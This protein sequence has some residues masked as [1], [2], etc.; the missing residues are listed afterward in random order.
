MSSEAILVPSSSSQ[1]QRQSS[2]GGQGRQPTYLSTSFSPIPLSASP[3]ND[4]IQEVPRDVQEM[5]ASLPLFARHGRTLNHSDFDDFLKDTSSLI[6][7]RHFSPGDNVIREGDQSRAI[8][9]IVKGTV[10]VTAEDGEINYAELGP[11]SHFG[12]IGVLFDI[13]RTA[14]VTAKTKCTLAVLTASELQSLL[15]N[16]PDVKEIFET[17][18]KERYDA[19]LAA[20]ARLWPSIATATAFT[21]TG[22][23]PSPRLEKDSSH[24]SFKELDA[25]RRRSR[26]PFD[27]NSLPPSPSEGHMSVTLADFLPPEDIAASS[28]STPVDSLSPVDSSPPIAP[29]ISE[30]TMP[31]TAVNNIASLYG[32]RRR[33]SV[34]VWSDDRLMQFA[35]SVS[36][37]SE[38]DL[39]DKHAV[40]QPSALRRPSYELFGNNRKCSRNVSDGYGILGKDCMARILRFLDFKQRMR[41]RR[42]SMDILKL[43]LDPIVNLTSSVDLS[44]WNKRVDDKVLQDVLCFCGAGLKQLNLR[45]CWSITDRGILTI[46][47]YAPHIRLLNL[48]SVWEITDAALV[49]LSQHCPNLTVVDL[50]NCRK[51]TSM[52]LLAMLDAC[53]VE[54]LRLSYCKSLSDNVMYHP[55]WR[56]VRRVNFQRCTGVGDKGF[57]GWGRKSEQGGGSTD[58]SNDTISILGEDLMT[59][60]TGSVS[61]LSAFPGKLTFALTCLSLSDCSFLTDATIISLPH[62]PELTTLSLSFCCALSPISIPP[63][64]ASCPNLTSLDVSFCGSMMT[65]AG[66]ALIARGLLALEMLSLR[67]CIQV[68]ER[69]LGELN[70]LV[71]LRILNIG[72]LKVDATK[73]NSLRWRIIQGQG[74]EEVENEPASKSGAAGLNHRGSR[75]RASTA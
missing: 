20:R 68:T 25:S 16:Y 8:F 41:I 57:Q 59:A 72:S 27:D 12:E 40:R 52:G 46:A 58:V 43:L 5:L 48:A 66:L 18:A 28:S 36:E 70:A 23:P 73:A 38:R 49:A 56:S 32:G 30:G 26:S 42:C 3:T 50:T 22:N 21:A 69:G 35:Q 34:A 4:P 6:R 51:I 33:A 31:H 9:F 55:R 15:A 7:I 53:A 47:T 17:S 45:N 19:L 60:Q 62:L 13:L 37:K 11:G 29:A 54:D 74:F 75:G 2:Y 61:S 14:T 10:K 71:G 64:V 44:T 1:P 39:K 63:L 67:G 24:G 65:D